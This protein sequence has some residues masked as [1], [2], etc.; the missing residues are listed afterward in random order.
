MPC[1]NPLPM[2]LKTRPY[3]H[4][5]NAFD[6]VCGL[7]GLIDGM[8]RSSG[9]ALMMEMGTGKTLVAIAV[10]GILYQFGL[11][12]KVLIV[13]P[14]SVCG[15]WESEFQTHARYPFTF[16]VLKGSSAQKKKML[17]DLPDSELQIVCVNYE[18]AWRI[19]DDIKEF[20]P[21]LI[22]ADEA[23]KIKEGRSK[24][25]KCMHTLG[26]L[27]KYKLLLTGTPITS[28][29][30]QLDIYSEYRYLNPEIFGKS[31]Y[32][33]R[34]RFFDMG[35]YQH[36]VPI[37]RASMTDEFL[38]KMHSIAFRTTKA[39]CLDLPEI[40]EEQRI[41]DLEPQ[42]EKMY[43]ELR[44]ESYLDLGKTEVTAPNILT[45]LLR[46][47]QFTGGHITD[48]DGTARIVSRA[49]LDA[50]SDIIDSASSEKKKLVI[51]ARFTPEIDDIIELLEKK[52]LGYAV[53]RG[54]VKNR[55]EEIRRFQNDPDCGF[56]VGQI[57]AAGTGLTLTASST[58]VFYSM[59]F[60]YSDFDQ[61]RARIH[62]VSQKQSCQYIYLICRNT[63]D[64][65][66]LSAVQDKKDL[67]KILVDDYRKG[68]N[69]FS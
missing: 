6:F 5:Q 4:Q 32:T 63:I 30:G 24:Q 43:Q 53:I 40:I 57:Q 10:A 21:D 58:M 19:E 16:T 26:D 18:S 15:V 2:P 61:A 47:Q 46:L 62:R 64:Q 69:P 45:R 31:F 44:K 13:C 12:R 14:L 17:S 8:L 56:F 38:Q 52:K 36:H 49:K 27:A 59:N 25:S 33:F 55:D 28:Q 65:R 51:M 41:I 20:A 29:A 68:L 50:L 48:D 3:L 1:S 54:G 23:H 37:F 34:N 42:A 9:A 66:V 39:E 11:I 35:G 22:V 7:F 67:A 60:S